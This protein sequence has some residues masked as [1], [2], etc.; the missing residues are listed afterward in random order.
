MHPD[1]LS[2]TRG[3]IYLDS[4][5]TGIPPQS[6]LDAVQQAL[7]AGG[8][9]GRSVHAKGYRASLIHNEARIEIARFLEVP[10]SECIFVP[11]STIGLNL[12]AQGWGARN[13]APGDE[14]LVSVAEH[15][16]NFLPWQRLAQKNG[17]RL[18]PIAC[19]ATGDLDLSDLRSKLC[20]RTQVVALNQVS[21]VTGAV[22][23][24]ATVVQMVRD[25]VARHALIVVDGAQGMAHLGASP[26]DWGCDVYTFSGHKCYGVPGAALVWARAQVWEKAE[27]LWVGGGSVERASFEETV[28]AQGP[29]RFESGTVNLAAIVGMLEGLRYASQHRNPDRQQAL[30]WALVQRLSRV[31]G[32]RILGAPAQRMSCLS[33]VHQGLHAHDLGTLLDSKGIALRVGHHCAHRMLD[34]FG[35]RQSLRASFSHFNQMQD[36]EALGSALEYAVEVLG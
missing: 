11:S 22:T 12:I 18:H 28:W 16:A 30:L 25:T 9:P 35:V 2:L 17:V 36:I 13:L 29:A 21:N 27:P 34:H 6:V 32:L 20:A 26:A 5:T 4:A 15:N 3:E 33:W 19:T 31:P 14:I 24:I 1:F 8:S 10:A 7:L 23:D